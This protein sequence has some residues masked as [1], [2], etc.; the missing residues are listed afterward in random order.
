VALKAKIRDE[1]KFASFDLLRQQIQQDAQ[2]ARQLL[3][4]S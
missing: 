1:I 2:K 4:A 3:G